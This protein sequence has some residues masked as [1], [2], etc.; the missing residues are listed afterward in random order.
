MRKDISQL[1][2]SLSSLVTI[3]ACSCKYTYF[4]REGRGRQCS[5]NSPL[6]WPWSRSIWIFQEISSQVYFDNDG[7]VGSATQRTGNILGSGLLTRT[8]FILRPFLQ[9][10]SKKKSCLCLE[11]KSFPL[12]LEGLAG[13]EVITEKQTKKE[14]LIWYFLRH[15]SLMNTKREMKKSF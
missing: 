5:L 2:D 8:L 4:T 11:A 1:S 3:Y 12:I 10:G 15:V 7:W 9:R 6:R 14:M 13:A